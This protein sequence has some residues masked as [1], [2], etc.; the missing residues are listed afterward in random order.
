MRYHTIKDY[1]YMKEPFLWLLYGED[2]ADVYDFDGDGVS[3]AGDAST[4]EFL[5]YACALHIKA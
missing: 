1:N 3:V 4:P 2:L 5:A